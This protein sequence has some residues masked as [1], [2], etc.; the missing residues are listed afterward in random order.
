MWAAREATL[1]CGWLCKSASS[2]R[3]EDIAPAPSGSAASGTY[4][5]GVPGSF[6]CS[7][8]VSGC[9]TGK[10]C[11]WAAHQQ[12]AH[13]RVPAEQLADQGERADGLSSL[14]VESNLGRVS[15]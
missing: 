2:H 12:A 15:G 10:A 5:P 1:A 6:S 11:G 8:I 13:S 7:G 9:K 4:A 14:R 3:Q